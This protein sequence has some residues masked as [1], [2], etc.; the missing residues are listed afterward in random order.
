MITAGER[1]EENEARPRVEIAPVSP[2]RVH[3][4]RKGRKLSARQ[5]DLLARLLP[6][7]RAGLSG[8]PPAGGLAALFGELVDEVWLEIG[9]GGGEHLVWQARNQPRVGLIGAEPFING[10][11]SALTAIEE[12]GL[13]PRVRLHDDDVSPL[14]Q[15]LPEQSLGRVFMLFPDPW[16]K[17][18]HR[19]RRLL[20]AD[21]LDRLLTLLKPGGEF[22]FASD[23]QDYAEAA[24]ELCDAH[25]ALAPAA[26][27]TTANRD[28]VPDWPQTRYEQ[29]ALRAG[30][31]STFL[32]YH[33]K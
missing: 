17:L 29:K 24:R 5:Q 23:I 27:F 10:V 14:L 28:A 19:Q 6:E 16:P 20:S 7:L 30:R 31:P 22:R 11:V 12:Q 18:R 33:R 26:S 13:H 8:P 15:W 21:V 32:I 1:V 25:A 4:R 9:F 2:R 3:G